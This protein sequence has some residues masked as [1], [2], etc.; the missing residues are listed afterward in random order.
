[1]SC[2]NI[3]HKRT[4]SRHLIRAKLTQ[5]RDIKERDEDPLRRYEHEALGDMVHLDLKKLWNFNEE[6]LRDSIT[7]NRLKSVNKSVDSKC[8]Q[9]AV[10]DYLR[11]PLRQYNGR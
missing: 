11:Y 8:M 5:Q 7:G 1:M 9:V 3:F 6:G 10:D 4:V 2:S